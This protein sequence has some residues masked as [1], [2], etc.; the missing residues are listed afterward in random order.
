M[1]EVVM[2][3]L[4]NS[5]E[6]GALLNTYAQL[7]QAVM[8]HHTF[9]L[10]NWRPVMDHTDPR[11]Q[12]MVNTVDDILTPPYRDHDDM[13]AANDRGEFICEIS[14]QLSML[15][16]TTGIIHPVLGIPD[17]LS[18]Y[19]GFELRIPNKPPGPPLT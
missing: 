5:P 8:V 18:I 11:R 4:M 14:L 15:I 7:P 13:K 1:F 17:D 12:W 3:Q 6:V 2:T 19:S 9:E 16:D 10:P